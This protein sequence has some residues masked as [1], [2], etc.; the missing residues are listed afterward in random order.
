MGY[1]LDLRI[2]SRKLWVIY[3]LLKLAKATLVHQE[4]LNFAYKHLHVTYTT[5]WYLTRFLSRIK[6]KK[7]KR[8]LT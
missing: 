4:N 5:Y 2:W 3:I 8:T 7:F 6:Q 1:I